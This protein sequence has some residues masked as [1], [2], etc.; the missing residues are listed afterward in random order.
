M[1]TAACGGVLVR[2][3]VRVRLRSCL[4][5]QCRPAMESPWLNYPLPLDT[6]VVCFGTWHQPIALGG[7]GGRVGINRKNRKSP[8]P[9]TSIPAV[10]G[11][12]R[13]ISRTSVHELPEATRGPVQTGR[14]YTEEEL[15]KI[16]RSP[17]QKCE[18]ISGSGLSLSKTS[19]ELLAP[20]TKEKNLFGKDALYHFFRRRHEAYMATSQGKTSV[21]PRCAVFVKSAPPNTIREFGRLLLTL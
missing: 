2:L 14:G 21:L 6:G 18:L 7:G 19:S 10:H 5:V 3:R 12:L 15:K 11:S 17:F 16:V 13:K 1:R 8:S 9:P 20:Q 4:P